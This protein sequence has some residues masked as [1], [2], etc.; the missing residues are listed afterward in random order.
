[1]P[2]QL[3]DQVVVITGASSGIGRSTALLLGKAGAKVVLAARNVVGL[4]EVGDDINYLSGGEALV[5]P[6]DVTDWAQVER[7]AHSAMAAFGR[8][9]TWVN[10]AGVGVYATAGDTSVEETQRV[11]QTNFMGVVHGVKAALPYMQ[12][13][14]GG[15]I[16][17]IGS[18]E[19]QAAL[20]YNSAYAASKH[21]IKG[22]TEALQ[23]ELDRTNSAIHVTLIM[24]AAINTPFFNHALSKIGVLPRPAGPVYK[25]EVVAEA[26]A[27]AAQHTQR[28][29]Y[30]GS[31]GMLFG[32]MERVCP[33]LTDRVMTAGGAMFRAQESTRPDNGE[34]TLFN[35]IPE[36]GRVE[37]DFEHL[38][39]ATPTVPKMH[40]PAVIVGAIVG[41]FIARR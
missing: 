34:T 7:L 10:D 20:P 21:A 37:G 5:V 24:P 12:R 14:G 36:T 8:I 15:T 18:V 40:L 1:M 22:Y 28:N 39:T 41:L 17:N 30:V 4:Q 33:T 31:G 29:V 32:M 23:M 25:P 35:T 9:D 3:K 2:P 19:S 13:Q 11:M 27:Y 38:V 16:I 26:I 6:T